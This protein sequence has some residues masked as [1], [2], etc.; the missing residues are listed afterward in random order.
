[1][2][3]RV[4]LLAVVILMAVFSSFAIAQL[5]WSVGGKADDFNDTGYT[6]DKLRDLIMHNGFTAKIVN[7]ST[8]KYET[9]YGSFRNSFERRGEVVVDHATGRM[10]Q[11]STFGPYT[12]AE[13]QAYIVQLNQ[14]NYAGYS[15]WYLPMASELA[16]LTQANGF[17]TS[18]LVPEIKL[19]LD[20]NY[21]D[22]RGYF[23]MS[24]D[25]IS[26]PS[27]KWPAVFTITW[28]GPGSFGAMDINQRYPVKAV[29]TIY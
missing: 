17:N 1:M 7:N 25:F 14:Q 19:H 20:P 22:G 16:S 3:K 9:I 2:K 4:T 10:W 18:F 13:A 6:W 21:F 5:R 11:R 28:A 15:D 23:C 26:D 12:Y 24:S 27:I 8:R 29:R